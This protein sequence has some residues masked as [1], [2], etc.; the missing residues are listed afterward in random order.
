MKEKKRQNSNET[1]GELL[2]KTLATIVQ[3]LSEPIYLFIIAICI[4]VL[5]AAIIGGEHLVVETR[6]LFAFLAVAG[7]I[8]ATIIRITKPVKARINKPTKG[9]IMDKNNQMQS[10][11]KK[12]EILNAVQFQEMLSL[13]LTPT[14]Q[15]DLLQP[16]TKASFL[17]DMNRW[18]RLD[19][20]AE[21]IQR[22]FPE[23][24]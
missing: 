1:I 5:L 23:K 20:V 21:Y 14:E 6:V 12:L 16:I 3:K 2:V 17:N 9:E 22:K 7:I 24:K 13:L 19:I 18:G 11:L 10:L 4:I 15:D 8:T